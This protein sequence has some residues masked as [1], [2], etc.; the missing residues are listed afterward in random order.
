MICNIFSYKT[1]SLQNLKQCF[2]FYFR[3]NAIPIPAYT[4]ATMDNIQIVNIVQY[5]GLYVDFD[6]RW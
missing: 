6:L 4:S 1:A 2:I 3:L 5:I